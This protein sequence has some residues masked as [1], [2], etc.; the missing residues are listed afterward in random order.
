MS[1]FFFERSSR[2]RDF[3]DNLA[4]REN[5]TYFRMHSTRT[6]FGKRD[7]VI[8]RLPGKHQLVKSRT[9]ERRREWDDGQGDRTHVCGTC[10]YRREEEQERWM[11]LVPG[12]LWCTKGKVTWYTQVESWYAK[13][14]CDHGAYPTPAWKSCDDDVKNRAPAWKRYSRRREPRET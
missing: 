11:N 6:A 5:V 2:G 13:R 7:R 10:A 12:R 3:A 9:T 1:Q 4:C 14:V 8:T